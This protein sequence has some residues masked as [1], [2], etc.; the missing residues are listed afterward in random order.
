[1][2][3]AL[4]ELDRSSIL[5]LAAASGF[6]WALTVAYLPQRRSIS[7]TA[8]TMI[9]RC[10]SSPPARLIVVGSVLEGLPALVILAPLLLAIAGGLGLSQQHCGCC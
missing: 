9:P 8:S 3:N 5:I 1:M 6:S 10:S 7:C 4:P 2:R